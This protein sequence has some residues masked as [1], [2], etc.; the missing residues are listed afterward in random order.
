MKA[1]YIYREKHLME[2]FFD[3]VFVSNTDEHL[4]VLRLSGFD[5]SILG[6]CH[7]VPSFRSRLTILKI[8]LTVQL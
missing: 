3:V 7:N 4:E 2:G 8:S 5:Q 6:F 1:I